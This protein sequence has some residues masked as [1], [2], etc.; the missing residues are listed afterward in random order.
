M[1]YINDVRYSYENNEITKI[2]NKM[3]IKQFPDCFMVQLNKSELKMVYFSLHQT[4]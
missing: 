4:Y 2:G 3:V 1:Q